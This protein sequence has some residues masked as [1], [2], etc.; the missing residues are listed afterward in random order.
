VP[1]LPEIETIRRGIEPLVVGQI[2]K[3]INVYNSNLR[4]PVPKNISN[5]LQNKKICSV[6]RRGRYLLL[7]TNSKDDNLGEHSQALII[8]L[9]MSGNLQF[10]AYP[11]SLKKH[12]HVDIVLD[13]H[14]CLCFNDPRRFGALLLRETPLSQKLLNNLGIEPLSSKFTG[15][16]LY[17]QTRKRKMA[18]K[19]LIMNNR[20]V[21]GIGN[22]YANEALFLA[23]ID[24]RKPADPIKLPD[25][26]LLVRSIKKVLQKAI[27]NKGTTFRNF[28]TQN[29]D[30]GAFKNF[31]KVYGRAGQSCVNCKHKLESVRIAQRSTVYCPRCQK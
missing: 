19:M 12:D 23:G 22:I 15:K 27:K 8:H 4:W 10:L 14:T 16:Y 7:V 11:H 29:G 25:Y 1:E 21:T 20:I 30:P 9:G 17:Q 18:I 26:V 5:I 28:V 6:E 24:P 2:I 3:Q 31:L 13:N